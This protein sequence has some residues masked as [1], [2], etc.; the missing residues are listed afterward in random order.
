MSKIEVVST[1]NTLNLS[2]EMLHYNYQNCTSKYNP[3]VYLGTIQT[4]AI[5]WNFDLQNIEK[6]PETW[7]LNGPQKGEA[8]S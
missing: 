2:H 5:Q 7:P 4:I 6:Y 1:L 3:R 8:N